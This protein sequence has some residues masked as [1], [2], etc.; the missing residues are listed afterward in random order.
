MDTVQGITG[1]LSAMN[2]IITTS[3]GLLFN[4]DKHVVYIE[5]CLEGNDNVLPSQNIY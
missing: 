2:I 3:S 4:R 1:E 5:Y